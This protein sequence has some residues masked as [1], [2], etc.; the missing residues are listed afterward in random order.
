MRFIL[1]GDVDSNPTSLT[2]DILDEWVRDEIIEWPG[3]VEVVS[4]LKSASVFVLPS[5]YREGVPRSI[6]EAMATGLPIITSDI[7][8]CRDTVLD[9][10]N[11]F[12]IP[13]RDPVK[14]AEKM[15]YFINNPSR[16]IEMGRESRILCEQKFDQNKVNNIFF[17]ISNII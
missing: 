5:F 3:Q 14:L 7:P 8:G 4:W 16:V 15:I 10:V 17:K 6:Q 9:G 13:P 11:G 1:L 12:L 2:K